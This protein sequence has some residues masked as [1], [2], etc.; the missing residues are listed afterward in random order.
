MAKI[1]INAARVAAGLTQEEL[2]EKMGVSRQTIIN[3]ETG[4][5][6]M[7]TLYLYAFCHVTGFSEDD[8]LVPK[9][10]T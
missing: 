9:M 7:K 8:I 10:S 5:Q 2:A 3:W 4:K 1:P 6:E